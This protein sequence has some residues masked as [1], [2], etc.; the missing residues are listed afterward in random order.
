MKIKIYQEHTGRAAG[1][2]PFGDMSTARDVGPETIHDMSTRFSARSYISKTQK[3]TGMLPIPHEIVD[4]Y[5]FAAIIII[6]HP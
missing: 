4:V 3:Y 6:I 1:P 5:P 2:D